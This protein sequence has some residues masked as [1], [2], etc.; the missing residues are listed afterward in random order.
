L[1]QKSGYVYGGS[2]TVIL[3]PAAW[4]KVSQA[5]SPQ[6]VSAKVFGIIQAATVD[7]DELAEEV[8]ASLALSKHPPECITT[9]DC[10]KNVLFIAVQKRLPKVVKILRRN[11]ANVG[12]MNQN[13]WAKLISE[14]RKDESGVAQKTLQ[15]IT[16]YMA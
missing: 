5:L 16:V 6:A 11:G 4:A 3:G 2:M 12:Y 15:A 13:E 1:L 10:V 14:L 8:Q 7:S 9:S